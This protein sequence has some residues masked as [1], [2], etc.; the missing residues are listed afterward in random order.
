M[1]E[2]NC[3]ST[4]VTRFRNTL[5]TKLI[6][7]IN[8]LDDLEHPRGRY[9]SRTVIA[10]V[11]VHVRAAVA[12]DP[13]V[14]LYEIRDKTRYLAL[15]HGCIASNNVLVLGLGHIVLRHNYKQLGGVLI[16]P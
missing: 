4:S 6:A 16:L 5:T 13:R 15:H 8:K 10:V 2:I 12:I 14:D 7:R 3:G 11:V 1:Y 9:R